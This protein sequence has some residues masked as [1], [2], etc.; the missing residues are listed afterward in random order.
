VDGYENQNRSPSAI[1]ILASDESNHARSNANEKQ[2]N[3]EK[4]T[5]DSHGQDFVK[6]TGMTLLNYPT[7]IGGNI[8][9]PLWRPK[10]AISVTCPRAF[11]YVG[12]QAPP[13]FHAAT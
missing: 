5:G 6:I 10:A 4:S 1:C 2:S 3:V 12:Q 8:F 13:Q 11:D 7:L 9:N